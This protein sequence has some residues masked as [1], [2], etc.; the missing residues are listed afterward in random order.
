MDDMQR[1]KNELPLENRFTFGKNWSKFI[2]SHFNPE[3]LEGSIRVFQLF[4]SL[5]DLK[6]MT[7]IDVGCGSGLHSLAAHKMGAKKIASFDF[8]PKA[9]DATAKLKNIAGS[10]SNWTINQGSILDVDFVSNL[11][12][13]DFVYSWGVLHHTGS[14]WRA[15]ENTSSLVTPK[16]QMY[17]ALYSL[18]VQPNADYWL[19][20][21][22][23]YVKSSYFRKIMMEQSYL[24]KYY[25]GSS[26]LRHIVGFFKKER[27]RTRGMELMTDVRDWL[28]GWP[29][30]FVLDA[31]AVNFVE[32][33]GFKLSNIKKGEACTEFLFQRTN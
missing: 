5:P 22:Q 4:T 31:E 15:I 24:Y 30:E 9:V 3:R 1:I 12:K 27:G 17:L 20:T 13:F 19:V 18:D 6:D 2:D 14:V 21:K 10:P 28:G 32:N 26:I 11:G 33:L 8:D 16:G 25:Y 7:F 29:M 23:K